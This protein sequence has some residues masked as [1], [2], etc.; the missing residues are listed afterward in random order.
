VKNYDR[1][2]S[3][4]LNVDV[5]VADFDTKTP[6]TYEV[7]CKIPSRAT[8]AFVTQ[9]IRAVDTSRSD[10]QKYIA[11]YTTYYEKRESSSAE[12]TRIEP[13]IASI[14]TAIKEKETYRN[15][16]LGYKTTLNQMFFKKY[17]RFILEGTWI[18]EEHVDND[19][20][21]SDA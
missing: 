11:E 9:E 14:E 7:S 19:K 8:T 16:L 2:A 20:Y 21:Y 18:S 15:T 13:E 5:G 6:R 4:Y 1:T 3:F 17:S 12:K 10:V